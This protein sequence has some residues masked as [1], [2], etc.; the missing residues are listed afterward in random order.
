MNRRE[1]KG[2]AGDFYKPDEQKRKQ[3]GKDEQK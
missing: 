3:L 2:G 1:T